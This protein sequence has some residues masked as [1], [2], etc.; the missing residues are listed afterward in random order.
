MSR[1]A[2]AVLYYLRRYLEAKPERRPA[3]VSAQRKRHST[4]NKSTLWRH[5]KFTNEPTMSHALVYL[6]FLAKEKAIKAG[7]SSL[8]EYV[9]PELLK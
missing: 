5:L 9:K 8:F 2:R 1:Q 6:E 3:L 7:K 4:F